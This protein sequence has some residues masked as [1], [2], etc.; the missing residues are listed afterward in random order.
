MSRILLSL[1]KRPLPGFLGRR[2]H[3]ASFLARLV[4]GL[5]IEDVACPYFLIRKEIL[6][7]AP[8]QSK[9]AFGIIELFSKVNYL[10]GLFHEEQIPL[11]VEPSLGKWRD[12]TL[13]QTW[14]EANL[15][16]GSP[17]FSVKQA[18]AQ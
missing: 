2:G 4:F 3:T 18:E 9:G 11:Q 5:R 7:H 14:R 10:K 15:V 16:F 13:K 8:I 17:D 12:E 6:E 1:P